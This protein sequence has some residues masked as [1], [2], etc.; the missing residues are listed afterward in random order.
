MPNQNKTLEVQCSKTDKPFFYHHHWIA[1]L[2][3]GLV[4]SCTID[5]IYCARTPYLLLPLLGV[6]RSIHLDVSFATYAWRVIFATFAS[7]DNMN[8]RTFK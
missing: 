5:P 6:F 2:S 7:D 8:G 4:C 1:G 3:E